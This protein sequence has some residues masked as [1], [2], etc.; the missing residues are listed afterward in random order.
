[1]NSESPKVDTRQMVITTL[2][3]TFSHL[4]ISF[5][6]MYSWIIIIYKYLY[7]K[8]YLKFY[9]NRYSYEAKIRKTKIINIKES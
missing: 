7:I 5:I 1:M 2:L 6:F 3:K 4:N 9:I 8:I